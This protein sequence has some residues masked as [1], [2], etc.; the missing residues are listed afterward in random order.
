M[1]YDPALSSAR[2][3]T[4]TSSH[5]QSFPES[6]LAHVPCSPSPPE[7]ELPLLSFVA[8]RDRTGQRSVVRLLAVVQIPHLIGAVAFGAGVRRI[9]RGCVGQRRLVRVETEGREDDKQHH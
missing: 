4:I 1:R 2:T 6:T 3:L 8:S 9:A 5:D 7:V